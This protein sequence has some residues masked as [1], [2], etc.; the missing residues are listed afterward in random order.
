MY[1]K[2]MSRESSIITRLCI[3]KELSEGGGEVSGVWRGE[4][5]VER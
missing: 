1:V 3:T 5:C 2:R 4:W